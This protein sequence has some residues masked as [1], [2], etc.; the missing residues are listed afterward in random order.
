MLPVI[1]LLFQNLE[2]GGRPLISVPQGSWVSKLVWKPKGKRS[3]AWPKDL[4]VS[5]QHLAAGISEQACFSPGPGDLHTVKLRNVLPSVLVSKRILK[6]N[7]FRKV[8][9]KKK[10]KK[11]KSQEVHS[12]CRSQWIT[13]ASLL[14]LLCISTKCGDISSGMSPLPWPAHF[15][16]IIQASSGA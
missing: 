11:K 10:K 1:F 14:P 16:F 8:Y 7:M 15:H 6:E 12:T 4:W 5:P 2:L 9:A 13:H 3:P